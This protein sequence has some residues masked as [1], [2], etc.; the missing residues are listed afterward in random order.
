MLPH[1]NKGDRFT[2]SARFH[3]KV[4]D[5]VNHFNGFIS[6][7]QKGNSSTI[8]V[9][10]INNTAETIICGSP[11]AFGDYNSDTKIFQI[12]KVTETDKVFAVLPF[13][14]PVKTAGSAILLGTVAIKI[15]GEKKSYAMP[16][17]NSYD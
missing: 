3:N 9:Q 13:E 15:N 11:V 10:V 17:A 1:V 2:P 5:M 6:N 8:K 16:K 7:T 4:A 14:L 12:R